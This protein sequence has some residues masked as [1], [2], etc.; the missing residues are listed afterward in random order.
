M[1]HSFVEYKREHFVE[2]VFSQIFGIEAFKVLSLEIMQVHPIN[3]IQY[4]M[5]NIIIVL[6]LIIKVLNKGSSQQ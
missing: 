1:T 2:C 5:V 3:I 6:L 4:I